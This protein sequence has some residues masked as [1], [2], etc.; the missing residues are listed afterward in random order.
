LGGGSFFPEKQFQFNLERVCR[1]KF[2]EEGR[3]DQLWSW[4]KEGEYNEDL[5]GV[6]KG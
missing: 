1:D 2:L 6:C 5:V 4:R 3:K